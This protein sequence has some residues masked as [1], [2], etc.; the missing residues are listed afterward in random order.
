ML[1]TIKS[2]IQRFMK[3]SHVYWSRVA[4][5]WSVMTQRE[6]E[7]DRG[8][9]GLLVETW[10]GLVLCL[11]AIWRNRL[12]IIH[13]HLDDELALYFEQI[14]SLP[15]TQIQRQWIIGAFF[16]MIKVGFLFTETFHCCTKRK[17]NETK[18]TLAYCTSTLHIILISP[19]SSAQIN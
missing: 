6:P 10:W 15:V 9:Y 13:S 12:T 2:T 16:E 4:F 5:T 3:W 14:G 8:Q 17:K 1:Q 18:S 11:A 19:Q 7:G